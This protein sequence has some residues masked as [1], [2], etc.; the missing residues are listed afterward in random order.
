MRIALLLLVTSSGCL[1]AARPNPLANT[2]IR[3][4]PNRGQTDSN[5]LFFAR[6]AGFR[7]ALRRTAADFVLTDAKGD[8]RAIRMKLAGAAEQAKAQGEDLLPGRSNYILGSNPKDWIRDV[9]Q[10]GRVR[11]LGVYPGV[12]MV[13]YSRAGRLEYDF[14][15]APGADPSRIHLEYEG[16]RATLDASGDLILRLPGGSIRQRKPVAYQTTGGVKRPVE[17]CYAIHGRQVSMRLGSYDPSIELVIDPVISYSSFLGGAAGDRGAGIAVDSQGNAYV[18]GTTSS[19]AFAKAGA[20]QATIKG[21]N[22]AFV[23]KVS[24][25]GGSVIHSTFIG[26]TQTTAGFGH[27]HG[28]DIWVDGSGNVIVAGTTDSADFPVVAG[29]AQTTYGG[30]FA[31][32]FVLKLNAAGNALLFSTYVGGAETDEIHGVGVDGTGAIYVAGI[33]NSTNFPVVAAYQ[34]TLKGTRDAFVVKLNASAT[35]R[36]YSTY[37]GGSQEDFAFDIAV[38]TAGNAFVAGE[39]QSADFPVASAYQSVKNSAGDAFL[40][41]FLPGGALAFSTFLGGSARDQAF[42]V[43]LDGGGNVYLAGETASTNFP[44]TSSGYQTAMGGFSDAFVSKFSANGGT[45]LYSTYLG[46]SVTDGAFGIAVDAGGQAHITGRTWSSNFPL[47]DAFQTQ[48]GGAFND[49]FVAK[50]N[51]SGS[52]LIYSSYL[53][54]SKEDNPDNAA[55]FLGVGAV[56]LD[57]AGNAYYTGRTDSEDFP[58]TPGSFQPVFGGRSFT[59]GDDSAF[60]AFVVKIGPGGTPGG[61]SGGGYTP[62]VTYLNPAAAPVGSTAFDIT[63]SGSNFTPQSIVRINGQNRLTYYVAAAQLKATVTQADTSFVGNLAVTVYDPAGGTSTAALSLLITGGQG[64]IPDA[65]HTPQPADYGAEI[66]QAPTLSWT[67]SAAATTYE[68]YFGTAAN[69]PLMATVAGTTYTP[70]PL[71][72]QTTYYWRVAARNAAANI[73]SQ[74]WRFTT[75]G[76]GVAPGGYR[77]VPVAPC[78]VVDTRAGEGL[79][80]AFGPPALASNTARDFPIAAGRCG[81]PATARAYSVNVTAVP[82]EP[83]G[84][85]SMWPAG[86]PQPLVSTLNAPHG[87]VV[88]NAAVV[89][90]GANGSITVLATNRTDLVIDIN[91]YFDTQGQNSFYAVNPCRIADT[92]T[93]SGFNGSFGWPQL[94]AGGTR[95][96][97]LLAGGCGLSS[98]TAYSLNVTAVPNEPLAFLT[99]WPSGAG[100]PLVSTLNAMEGTVVANAAIVPAGNGGAIQTFATHGTNL[101]LDVNGYFGP[102]GFQSEM[103][104]HPI[105]PCRAAD[106]RISGAGAPVMAANEKRDFQISGRCGVPAGARA[107]SLNVTVVPANT[108]G[109]LTLWPGGKPKPLVSTLNSYLGRIVANAALVPAGNSGFVSVFVTDQTHVI[110]DVNGYFQ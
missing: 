80:G 65:P 39:A 58:T 1:A 68:V 21:A 38:D 51:S 74:T 71:Q 6:D 79:S 75:G 35:T 95:E 34:S 76:T 29:G 96:F 55:G 81:I 4:E 83:L 59:I 41:K 25:D 16:T 82:L 107:Y 104:F 62:I 69:P 66:G 108:L 84:F 103:L 36:V 18:T 43:A 99:V 24:P 22:D 15:V 92:R 77:Y 109:Y 102:A 53:G 57:A 46:G 17:A 9:A 106:T 30:G 8:A 37:L 105:T 93:G 86:Q 52:A 97:P 70:P 2:P 48:Y 91:G 90:A 100:R 78:R 60:D 12:D 26:G 94:P 20:F 49:A 31:D 44:A 64:Q 50:L 11:Y 32:G 14:I 47:K 45:L 61:G 27:D 13:Y 85:L 72:G 101:V 19:P 5:V 63:I 87:G 54:G 88:A 89:P 110:V 10:Y 3:F 42:G 98:A 67:G 40:S 73:S 23:T 33:T 56:A 28:R 7:V